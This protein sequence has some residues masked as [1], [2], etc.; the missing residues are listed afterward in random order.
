MEPQ[1]SRRFRRARP[2]EAQAL[3]DLQNR[4]S[5]HWGYP[6]GFFDWAPGASEIP[7]TY[8]RDNPVYLLEEGGR[9]VGF[10]GYTEE[11]GGLLLDK[12]FVD[13]DRI[14]TGCGKALWLHAIETARTLGRS[15]IVIGSDPN[16]A[17]F[18]RAMGAT[19]YAEKPTAEPTW[20]VQMFR[21]S[22][23]PGSLIRR[24]R[25]DEAGV[26]HALTGRSVLHWG[27]EPEFL[28]WESESIAVT[29]ELL[30]R[31]DTRVL[32]EDGVVTG[33]YT[34]VG[35]P[36]EPSLD[37][38]FVEPALIGTGRGKRL[39]RHAVATARQTGAEV[40]TFAADPNAA[41]FYR[42]MGAE[43]VREEETTRPGWNLQ[44]FRYRLDDS[45][46]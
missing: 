36:P 2:D 45:D 27:Y 31:S 44:W 8:V 28:D 9:V 35:E 18:Y 33:Y 24:A 5:T 40:M 38:L 34:L 20:T 26:L 29:P 3:A 16:A 25:Q 39:W 1:S 11:D 23:P 4:S 15:E 14:G 37:K 30:A 7:E 17:A 43:W 22:I 41:P 42:A 13:L 21:F 10:Y 32:E 19:W 46:S 6:P 12:L